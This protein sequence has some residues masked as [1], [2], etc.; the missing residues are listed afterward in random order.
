MLYIYCWL[1]EEGASF[2]KENIPEA[3]VS[4]DDFMTLD[5][6]DAHAYLDLGLGELHIYS[7]KNTDY[8]TM[9]I[10]PAKYFKTIYILKNS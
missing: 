7:T 1:S 3:E 10:I 6:E 5:L 8:K 2:V 9:Y 4:K